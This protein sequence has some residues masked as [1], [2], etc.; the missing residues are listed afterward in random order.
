MGPMRVSR[1]RSRKSA[2]GFTLVELLVVL[3]ILSVLLA[4][5]IPVVS[6]QSDAADVPRVASDLTG[7]RDGISLFKTNVRQFPDDIE[8]LVNRIA[9]DGS[10]KR[11][12]GQNYTPADRQRWQGP[13]LEAAIP[14]G[15]APTAA[16][17]GTAFDASVLNGLVC[18]DANA[19]A[20]S[21]AIAA[22][23]AC[24]TAVNNDLTVFVTLRLVGMDSLEFFQVNELIDGAGETNPRKRGRLRHG[25]F[26]AVDTVY[27]LAV[28]IPK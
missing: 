12:F 2:R 8:D 4:V 26:G 28:P 5:V 24:A 15:T 20:D 1:M 27:Y 23:S 10:D 13:Y 25:L 19:T 6:Q 18:F 7:I 21:V 22:G 16:A 3:L 9:T 17:L 11:L 14:N